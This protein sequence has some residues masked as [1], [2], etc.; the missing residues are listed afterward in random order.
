MLGKAS[1][2]LSEWHFLEWLPNSWNCGAN[3]GLANLENG[4]FLMEILFVDFVVQYH[5][6]TSTI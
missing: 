1:T 3:Q 5:D 6:K 4:H 2:P